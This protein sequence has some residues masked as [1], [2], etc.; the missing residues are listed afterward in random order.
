[1]AGNHDVV[2]GPLLP[3]DI[4]D[5]IVDQLDNELDELRA[6]CLVSK[7]WVPRTRKH[8]FASVKFESNSRSSIHRWKE[9]FPDPST[10]P[11]QYTR[12]LVFFG[13]TPVTAENVLAWIHSFRHLVELWLCTSGLDNDQVSLTKLRGLSPTLRSLSFSLIVSLP[14]SE[15]LGLICSFPLLEDL[16]LYHASKRDDETW[17]TP[18]TSPKLTGT[19]ELA[20]YT[21]SIARGL[22]AFPNSLNFSKISVVLSVPDAQITMELISKCSGTLESLSIGY[23]GAF[24]LF[25]R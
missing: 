2:S 10:A 19:L 7:S 9:I 1:M 14:F 3:S 18:S 24:P 22:L 11:T 4:F 15:I 12:S 5:L 25:L 23:W 16:Y 17:E 20:G 6:C 21:S 13:L 8:L